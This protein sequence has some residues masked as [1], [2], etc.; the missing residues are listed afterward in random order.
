MIEA[1]ETGNPGVLAFRLVGEM[2]DSDYKLLVP[3]VEAA[4][5]K[6][7]G[8]VRLLAD[9][10][11]FRGWDLHAAWDDFKF[12]LSHWNDIEKVAVL[13]DHRSREWVSRMH[14][15]RTKGEVRYFGEREHP[16]AWTWL[17]A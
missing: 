13:G 9:L 17:R 10:E 4:L 7:G 14:W 12:E 5:K 16:A 11:D 1:I 3:A 8:K 15:P 2:H 6:T